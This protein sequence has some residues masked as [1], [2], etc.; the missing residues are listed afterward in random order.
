M[1]P[2]IWDA[3][4]FEG[5]KAGGGTLPGSVIPLYSVNLGGPDNRNFIF[6]GKPEPDTGWLICDGGSDGRDGSVPDLRNRSVM[7]SLYSGD[8]GQT[9][10]VASVIPTVSM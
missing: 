9:G 4:L 5:R 3:P 1:N 10:G 8:T 2:A 6:W 7:C